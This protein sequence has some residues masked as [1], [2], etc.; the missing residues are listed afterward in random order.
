M[1]KICCCRI[2]SLQKTHN[3]EQKVPMITLLL[4][5]YA[6]PF[7]IFIPDSFLTL[8]PDSFL[9]LALSA[10]VGWTTTPILV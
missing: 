1:T 2:K 4:G 6:G 7:P 3:W 8:I 5:S 10:G 9:T